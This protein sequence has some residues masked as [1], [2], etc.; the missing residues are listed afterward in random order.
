MQ[1]CGVD[2][3]S[4]YGNELDPSCCGH[5]VKL[6]EL[7][8]FKKKCTVDNSY[9]MGCYSKLKIYLKEYNQLIIWTG[10]VFDIFTVRRHFLSFEHSSF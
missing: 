1:C 8:S 9:Q 10:I 2:D 5:Y 7:E 3:P 6:S 4:D